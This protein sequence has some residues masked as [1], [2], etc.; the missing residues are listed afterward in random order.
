M[1]HNP[2]TRFANALADAREIHGM[3]EVPRDPLC[4]SDDAKIRALAVDLVRRRGGEI[5]SR[6]A[7]LLVGCVQ[8]E[9]RK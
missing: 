6:L 9:R 3:G 8:D 2:L 1:I 4:N 5:A 7:D